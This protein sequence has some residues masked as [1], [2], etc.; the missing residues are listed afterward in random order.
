MTAWAVGMMA[1]ALIFGVGM[2]VGACAVRISVVKFGD[3]M[4]AH[5]GLWEGRGGSRYR[6]TMRRRGGGADG[7]S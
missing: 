5:V 3:R 7:Q 1:G 6:F 4:V 2:L